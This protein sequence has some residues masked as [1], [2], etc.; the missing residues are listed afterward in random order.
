MGKE[1]S[2]ETLQNHFGER[3]SVSPSDIENHGRS[4][5]YFSIHA[6]DAVVYPKT[7][8]EVVFLVN[9][10]QEEYTREENLRTSVRGLD[11]R[12]IVLHEREIPSNRRSL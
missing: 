9:V 4:E 1:N 11:A 5:S 6:P 7:T 12:G 2:F 10:C 3:W 8:Q